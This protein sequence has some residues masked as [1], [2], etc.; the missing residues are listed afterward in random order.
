VQRLVSRP[1]RDHSNDVELTA[2]AGEDEVIGELPSGPLGS[3][4]WTT[5]S[6]RL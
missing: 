5:T 6:P 1:L 4:G 3:E 2:L